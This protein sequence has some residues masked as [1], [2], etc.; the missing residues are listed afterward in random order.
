MVEF[1]Q[2][3]FL[4][5]NSHKYITVPSGHIK[6]T[7]TKIRRM[8]KILLF[9]CCSLLLLG[10]IHAQSRT[11][12]GTVLDVNGAPISGASVTVKGSKQGTSS[13]SDGKFSL[14]VPSSAKTLVISSVN[15]TLSEFDISKK[16]D[17]GP[18]TLV[19]NDASLNEVVVVAYGQAK[20]TNI[21]GSVTTI[22]GDAVADKPFT[23]VDKALQGASAGVEVS[24]TS[25][26]P[27]SAT[28]IRI[29]G[30]GSI[31]A[32]AAPL[33]VIDGVEATTGDQSSNTTTANVLATMNP[34][35]I[36]SIT[37]LKDA[38]STAIYGSKGSNG[39][40]LVTTKKGRAGKTRVS[41]SAE[42]GQNSQAFNPSNRPETSPQYQTTLQQGLINSG[43]HGNTV[44]GAN[45]YILDSLG[46]P[47]NWP[48]IN[49]NWHDVV[50]QKGNQSQYNLSISGGTEKTQVYFSGGYFNQI[51]TALASDFKRY[52]GTISVSQKATDRLTFS[53]SMSVGYSIQHT[54][55]NSGAYGNP[56]LESFL[57]LPW[58]TPRNSDGSL[59]YGQYDSLGEFPLAPTAFNPLVEATYNFN[60]YK[61]TS[62]RGNVQ[63]VYKI[64]DNLSLTSRYSGEYSD[65]SEDQYWNP[66][67]GDGYSSDPSAAGQAYSVYTRIYDWTWSNFVDFKQNLSKDGTFYFDLKPGY[68][69]YEYNNYN[70]QAGAKGFPQTFDLK[71]LASAATPTTTLVTPTASSTASEFVLGDINWHDKYV[72]T[73]SFRRDGSSVFGANH[74]Y[75]NFYSVGGTWNIN[76][77]DF[78]KNSDVFSLL[79]LRSSYG[80]TGNQLGFGLYTPLATYG[81][82]ANY[83]GTPGSYPNS[84]GNPNLTWEKNKIFN[85]GVDFGLLKD[86]IT[87]TVEWY[88]RQT[89]NLLLAVPLSLTSGVVS[90]TQANPTQNENVGGLSNKGL[91]VTLGAKPIL[92]RDFSWDISFNIAHNINRVTAL[93][94]NNPVPSTN[95]YF[96]YTV[97][98]DF[99]A[100]YMPLW[101]G[102]NSSNGLPL[103]YTDGTKKTVT[104]NYNEA[105][106]VLSD[107]YTATP[108]IFGGLNN[109]FKYKGLSLDIQFNYNFGNYLYDTWGFITNSDGAYVGGYNQMNRQLQAWTTPGQKASVPQIIASRGDNSNGLSTRYLY[110][111]DYIRLRN[112]QLSY[113]L[114]K[115]FIDKLHIASASIYAR[116]T[117]LLTFATDKYLPYDPE[118]GVA[119]STNFEVYIPKTIAGGIKIGF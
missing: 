83:N 113:A 88:D 41:F 67:Y 51:G 74:K 20:K 39:V 23:S 96:Q 85:V 10:R 31:S 110:R 4:N 60:T 111:G 82:G 94:Q 29:R 109:T 7:K 44:D 68:E 34:D 101:A 100:Y 19:V 105:N 25:G 78:L 62:L 26:A 80:E 33:W 66:F 6:K 5:F 48:S 49:T 45:T 53:G 84:V 30:I 87:G 75:G 40:I 46:Y 102:V 2:G 32:S 11:I 50:T 24:S 103:W 12:T 90:S 108:K 118:S 79:K 107:K 15:F 55:F 61:Q 37:I 21:T 28:D 92:T 58:Y 69:A 14:N 8:R 18:L 1:Y 54:P 97:G 76:E 95:Y 9:L 91:E 89:T 81:Y 104:S 57:L 93:Y 77:E 27:G 106:F 115:S 63:G 47:S 64:L 70:L 35:D 112:V 116:G 3:Y 117:N 65:I 22:K 73:G 17:L 38:A 72:V 42:V 71:Y 13:G 56:I 36:E 98:H 114:P 43:Q 16:S 52:N 119:S 86:R 99:Q 59:R